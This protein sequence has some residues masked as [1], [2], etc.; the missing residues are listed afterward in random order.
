MHCWY[1]VS[2]ETD[3]WENLAI[4][5]YLATKIV[6]ESVGLYLWQN[7]KTVVIG[8]SQNPWRE[9]CVGL[10]EQEAGQLARRSTGGGA[11]YQDMGNLNFTFLTP[12]E[13]YDVERQLSVVQAACREMGIAAFFTGRN[14]LVTDGGRKFSG[15]AFEERKQYRIHHGTLMIDV[16]T[17]D[18]ARYLTPDADKLR[19]KGVRSVGSRVCNLKEFCPS[20]TPARL[21]DALLRAFEKLYAPAQELRLSRE[22]GDAIARLYAKYA[23]REWRFGRTPAFSTEL[24]KRFPWG[25]LTLCMDVEDGV[26][27]DVQVY[28]DALDI[29]LPPL[30]ERRLKGSGYEKAADRLDALKD[31]GLPETVVNDLKEW[32]SAACS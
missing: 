20:L 15:N 25:G 3:A 13:L 28:S 24:E 6:P 16:N 7:R 8:R 17:Q 27:R 22:D 11:V 4:E 1:F 29:R 19:A 32:L 10:L 18:M 12:A 14:D 30:L 26:I 21:S 2:S 31:D 9:C 23:S 5:A